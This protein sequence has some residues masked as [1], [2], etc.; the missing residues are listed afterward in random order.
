MK[1]SANGT[2]FAVIDVKGDGNCLWNSLVESKWVNFTPDILRENV[3]RQID[4]RL[5]NGGPARRDIYQVY[6]ALHNNGSTES[7]QSYMERQRLPGQ[8]ATDL[9]I[10]FFCMV[11]NIDVTSYSNHANGIHVFRALKFLVST[12]RLECR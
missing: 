3:F 9:D 8:W 6:R 10:T 2:N 4:C 7:I 1:F 5:N 12:L 11:M